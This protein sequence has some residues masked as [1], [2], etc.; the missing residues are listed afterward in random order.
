VKYLYDKLNGS[1]EDEKELRRVI[2]E[3]YNKS[4]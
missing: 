3:K 4:M 1:Y 2:L